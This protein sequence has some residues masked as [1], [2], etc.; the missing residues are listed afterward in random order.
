MKNLYI[1]LEFLQAQV[2]FLC[3]PSTRE[4]LCHMIFIWRLY[5][6]ITQIHIKTNLMIILYNSFF[7]MKFMKNS[8][9]TSKGKIQS[10]FKSNFKRKNSDIF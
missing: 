5:G 6:I 10:F 1:S 3:K 4:T 2:F 7:S 8:N 9:K